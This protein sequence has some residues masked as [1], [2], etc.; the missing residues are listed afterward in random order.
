[1]PDRRQ[2]EQS[3]NLYLL[4]ADYY[5]RGLVPAALEELL[6][7]VKL[8][9]RNADAHNLLGLVYLAQGISEE[10]MLTASCAPVSAEE[11]A[12]IDE[13]MH[14][15]EEHFRKAVESRENFSE[16]LNSLAVVRTYFKDYD[17]AL[18]YAKQA[19]DNPTYREPHLAWGNLGWASFKKKDYSK[20]IQQLRQ[21]VFMQPEFCV[22]YYRLGEVYFARKQYELAVDSL[23]RVAKNPKCPIQEA[24]H[25]LGLSYLKLGRPADGQVALD[26][27]RKLAPKSCV[28]RQCDRQMRLFQ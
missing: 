1:M 28:G 10:G 13:K 15:A 16:A 21:A 4:G 5:Q 8:D 19:V 17:G 23:E 26:R 3:H 2:I 12:P 7:S 6:K 25:L 22:G 24:H 9:P 20:A 14:K 27:C 18:Q 11:R